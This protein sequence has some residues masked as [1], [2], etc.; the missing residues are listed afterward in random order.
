MGPEMIL[1]CCWSIT[2]TLITYWL[3]GVILT[4]A[5]WYVPF[6]TSTPIS[7][8]STRVDSFD[9]GLASL[10]RFWVCADFAVAFSY[11]GEHRRSIAFN[12]R[13]IVVAC[14]L[15]GF[16]S[17]ALATYGSFFNCAIGVNCTAEDKSSA[18]ESFWNK[19][20]FTCESIS[21]HWF[22]VVDSLIL[23]VDFRVVVV[24][25]LVLM[26]L[27]HHVGFKYIIGSNATR[28]ISRTLGWKDMYSCCY[29]LRRR[30]PKGYRRLEDLKYKDTIL[31]DSVM[32]ATD[33][34]SP[35]TEWHERR[36]HG[37]WR[38]PE[39]LTFR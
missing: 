29:C 20:V 39:P 4:S 11:G 22:G 38:A 36:A 21:V 35:I 12:L 27:I 15:V 19:L 28:W 34:D 32:S 31:N 16:F 37:A 10:F 26:S 1:G 6:S 17:Y 8:W 24:S 7:D 23:P 9:V 25:L 13:L 5:S 3:M 14:I 18:S 30:D 2:I 33:D